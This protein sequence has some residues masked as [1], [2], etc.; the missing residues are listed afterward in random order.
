MPSVAQRATIC[1]QRCPAGKQTHAGLML[2]SSPNADQLVSIFPRSHSSFIILAINIFHY[3]HLDV[4]T[5]TQY[6]GTNPSLEN[7]KHIIQNPISIL[8]FPPS[9][10]NVTFT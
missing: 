10:P 4:K 5:L 1:A 9:R 3:E 7:M 6:Q 8:K 2:A